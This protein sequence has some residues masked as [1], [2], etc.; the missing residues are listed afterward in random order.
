[1][2]VLIVDDKAENLYLLQ[3]ILAGH[4][5]FVSS[6]REGK[7]ALEKARQSPP[8]LIISDILMPGM[9]GFAL[10]REWRQAPELKDI[11]FMF[12]T[13]TYTDPQDKQFALDLGADRF[14]IKPMEPDAFMVEV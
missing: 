3:A 2:N 13:A 7:E 9:D 4:G 1:M 10:C 8:D 12:Y 14:L 5:F 11:P 6:A